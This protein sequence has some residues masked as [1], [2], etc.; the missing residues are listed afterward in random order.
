T[1]LFYVN[2]LYSLPFSLFLLLLFPFVHQK[3]IIHPA[4]HFHPVRPDRKN[5]SHHKH[6]QRTAHLRKGGSFQSTYNLA[7]FNK[8]DY[9]GDEPERPEDG[10]DGEGQ[11][12][13]GVVEDE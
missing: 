3:R 5:T 10:V 4:S 12:S 6:S 11:R 1:P 8:K 7:D 13:V 9:G 2:I